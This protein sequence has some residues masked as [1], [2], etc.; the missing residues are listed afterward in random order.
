MKKINSIILASENN[1]LIK[2]ISKKINE[3][4]IL[5]N[6]N[7][8]N[9]E[10]ITK[11]NKKIIL[12]PIKFEK[13][14][15]EKEKSIFFEI[16]KKRIN[17]IEKIIIDTKEPK[18]ARIFSNI[19]NDE[20]T[21]LLKKDIENITTLLKSFLTYTNKIKIIILIHK[22]KNTNANFLIFKQCINKFLLE[23]MHSIN[24]SNKNTYINCISTENINLEYK[25]NIYPFK[26]NIH[27]KK[28]S[29]LTNTCICILKKN[30]KNKI[31]IA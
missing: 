14:N 25:K 2:L 9:L 23:L 31:I 24:A 3:N 11:N 15:Y 18:Y 27:L 12:Y 1:N 20:F 16:I 13:E 10:R 8:Y 5:I 4:I 30:I 19:S 29:D 21:N 22:E 6:E 7:I 17:N 28:I 26:K